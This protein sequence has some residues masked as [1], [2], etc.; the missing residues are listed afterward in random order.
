MIYSFNLFIMH[1]FVIHILLPCETFVMH[2]AILHQL[3]KCLLILGL[4][5]EAGKF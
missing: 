2:K 4:Q 5:K 1:T 3:R